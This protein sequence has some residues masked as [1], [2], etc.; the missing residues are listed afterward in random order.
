MFVGS[1]S[2]AGGPVSGPQLRERKVTLTA[3]A[4]QLLGSF[5]AAKAVTS[6]G[7][8]ASRRLHINA[9][10][11]RLSVNRRNDVSALAQPNHQLEVHP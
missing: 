10:E 6:S 9:A 11:R 3:K 2:L 1:Q 7:F 5:P 8:A 4:L